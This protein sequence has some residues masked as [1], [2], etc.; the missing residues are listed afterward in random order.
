MGESARLD[1]LLVADLD[2]GR[3]LVGL[4]VR[5]DVDRAQ[6]PV[7]LAG[8]DALL[9]RVGRLGRGREFRRLGEIV[10]AVEIEVQRRAD[11]R[12][13]AKSRQRR[14]G[15]PSQRGA[16]PFV[17][18]EPVVAQPDRRLDAELEA[19]QRA[20]AAGPEAGKSGGQCRQGFSCGSLCRPRQKRSGCGVLLTRT[21]VRGKS[22][23]RGAS[24]RRL[25]SPTMANARQARMSGKVSAFIRP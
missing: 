11:Q 16:A 5:D 22:R 18:V 6:E 15:E 14:A 3:N 7:A 9:L 17:A 12:D 21:R 10:L 20:V 24:T 2:R 13:A 4:L 1:H 8:A 25:S 19:D 23:A